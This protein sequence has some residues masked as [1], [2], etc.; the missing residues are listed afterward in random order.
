[1]TGLTLHIAGA[2]IKY[3]MHG[4]GILKNIKTFHKNSVDLII[5]H[6]NKLQLHHSNNYVVIKSKSKCIFFHGCH[7]QF[8]YFENMYFSI[9]NFGKYSKQ[10]HILCSTTNKIRVCIQIKIFIAAQN[11][12]DSAYTVVCTFVL[13]EML[14]LLGCFKDYN[15]QMN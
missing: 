7:V 2:F 14:V 5:F 15:T 13:M 8:R 1:M 10:G 3:H 9:K 6:C 4:I 11:T 12:S